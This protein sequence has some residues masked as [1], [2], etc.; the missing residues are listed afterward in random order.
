M[1]YT[2]ELIREYMHYDPETG[3]FTWIKNT[4]NKNLIGDRAGVLDARG[5]IAISFFN[6]KTT[7]HRLAF[8]YMEGA[9]PPEF[10]DHI[11]HIKHDNRWS[12]LRKVSKRQ[13]EM[14]RGVQANNMS[15]FTGV[16]WHSGTK[17]WRATIQVNG[18]QV[19][20]G[21][22]KD[23]EEANEARQAYARKVGYHTNHGV[24]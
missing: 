17:K 18:K 15:G 12:N 3:H 19:S 1:E 8:L 22:W 16:T 5:Y 2:K 11:N 13:N 21:L 6:Y 10:V 9:F 4:G 23:K 14:N 24:K 20:L 7:A